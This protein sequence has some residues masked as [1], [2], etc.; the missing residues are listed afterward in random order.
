MRAG[1]CVRRT[2]EIAAE[3]AEKQPVGAMVQGQ[4]GADRRQERADEAGVEV[5][6]ELV[7]ERG[8]EGDKLLV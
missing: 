5:A 6:I 3:F 7:K 8:Q 4:D 1:R 2:E